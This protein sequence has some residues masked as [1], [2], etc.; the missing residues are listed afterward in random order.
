MAST[1]KRNRLESKRLEELVYVKFN[2]K[3]NQ[4]KRRGENK[5][6]LLSNDRSKA[7]V[8]IL[9]GATSDD[10][11]EV[12]SGSDL[13]WRMVEAISGAAKAADN[14]R[15]SRLAEP[16]SASTS[17]MDDEEEHLVSDDDVSD[18]EEDCME[19][20]SREDSDD[21]VEEELH[22]DDEIRFDAYC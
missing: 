13:T 12:H 17:E 11:E 18:E 22:D 6:L 7:R 16:S 5:N 8:W 14:R 1:K 21:G 15:S 19:M 4:K 20:D 3:L 9:E 10:V 2:S